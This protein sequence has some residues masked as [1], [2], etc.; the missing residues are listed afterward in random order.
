MAILKQLRLEAP[1]SGDQFYTEAAKHYILKPTGDKRRIGNC[2]AWA[3]T[4]FAEEFGIW[5]KSANAEM[6]VQNAKEAGLQIS[7]RPE[8]GA[9]ACWSKGKVGNGADGAGH[10]AFVEMLNIDENNHIYSIVTSESGWSSAKE[11]WTTTRRND[12]NWGQSASYK[13]QGFIL[14]PVTATSAAQ[15][16][17]LREG[18][19]R[20]EVRQLQQILTV[21][22]YYGGVVDGIFGLKTL[23]AV[24]AFQFKNSL[25]VDGI[26]G[27]ATWKELMKK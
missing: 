27:P 23:G 5:L 16:C 21:K 20:G 14:P 6:W 24:L 2:V 11:F 12:P 7:N 9:I 26:C 19:T 22:G 25:K 10:I 17:T 4:R 1:K 13:F 8:P 15:M 18:A 3:G